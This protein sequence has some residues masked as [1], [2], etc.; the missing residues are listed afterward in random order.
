MARFKAIPPP[1]GAAGDAARAALAQAAPERMGERLRRLRQERA[2][3]Y[4]MLAER[5]GFSRWQ[6]VQEIELG[7][8]AVPRATTLHKLA[9][10]LGVDVR[11]LTSALLAQQDRAALAS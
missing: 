5:G 1:P 6:T 8:W 3:S 9:K 2:L 7:H 10:G 4:K 11:E